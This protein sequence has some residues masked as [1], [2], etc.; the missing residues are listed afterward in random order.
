[1]R[2]LRDGASHLLTKHETNDPDNYKRT[3][4]LNP[5][6]YMKMPLDSEGHV[7]RS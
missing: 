4:N 7:G 6:V 5:P 1:M 2:S 3:G